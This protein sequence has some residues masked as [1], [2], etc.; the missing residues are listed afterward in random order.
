MRRVISVC[1]EKGGAGK[2]TATVN[3][4]SGLAKQGKKVL[5][6]DL[7]QQGNASRSLGYI[8]DGK[9]T[10]SEVIYNLSAGIEMDYADTIRKSDDGVDYVPSSQTLTNITTFMAG[11]SDGNYILKRV[12]DNEVYSDYDYIIIDCRT[13]LDLLVSNSLNAS[14]H[15]VIP[16]ECGV[17]S[18]DGLE[19]MLDKVK[20]INNST[21]KKLKVLGILLN[22]VNRTNISSSIVESVRESYPTLTF[23]T[24]IP[25]YPAQAEMGVVTQTSCVNDKNSSMGKHFIALSEEIISLLSGEGVKNNG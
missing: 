12:L 17:F 22:K 25:F 1:S 18:F 14:T 2:T 15:V 4:A 23:K 5:V 24:A 8:K 6:I 20:S 7:D 19:K 21:N 10:I 16:V 3:I 9:P 13:L 11:D